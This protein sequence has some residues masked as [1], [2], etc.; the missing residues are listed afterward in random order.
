MNFFLHLGKTATNRTPSL[1]LYTPYSTPHV[2]CS[3]TGDSHVGFDLDDYGFQI[4]QWYHIAYTLS[5]SKKR[6]NLYI[7][8]KWVGSYSLT[9][10]QNQSI[11]FNDGPLYIGKS[12]LPTFHQEGIHGLIR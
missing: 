6:M 4:N 8:G 1:W 2:D 5:D 7:D 12:P 10:I 11:I 9:I 3:I